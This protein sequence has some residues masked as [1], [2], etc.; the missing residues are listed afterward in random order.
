M[1]VPKRKVVG[2]GPG[3]IVELPATGTGGPTVVSAGPTPDPLENY[4]ADYLEC[5][6]D[7]HAWGKAVWELIAGNI[8]ERIRQCARCGMSRVEVVNTRTWT[9]MG[10][11]PRYR[12]A[13]GY[14]RRGMGLAMEDYRKAHLSGDFA[15]A[16][17]DKRVRG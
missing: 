2:K 16:Q 12:G 11:G 7:R 9:R 10:P 1:A 5:R 3:N 17:K 14:S 4:S 13:P 8:S 6:V 15:R